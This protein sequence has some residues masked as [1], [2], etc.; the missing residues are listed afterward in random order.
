MK[1]LK[2]DLLVLCSLDTGGAVQEFFGH[3]IKELTQKRALKVS[4]FTTDYG[5][6]DAR[7]MSVILRRSTLAVQSLRLISSTRL[8]SSNL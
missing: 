8:S 7:S 4:I 6:P 3:L 5:E 2:A 1:A